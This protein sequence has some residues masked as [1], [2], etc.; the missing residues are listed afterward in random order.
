MRLARAARR[1]VRISGAAE[2]A[3]TRIAVTTGGAPEPS[4][5]RSRALDM[6]SARAPITTTPN[7]SAPM[8]SVRLMGSGSFSTG[9]F[10]RRFSG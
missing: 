5:P 6:T 9:S 3:A 4:N 10:L 1:A 8:E 7:T 2:M